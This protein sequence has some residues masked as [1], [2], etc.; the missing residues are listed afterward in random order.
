MSLDNTNCGSNANDNNNINSGINFSNN[1]FNNNHDLLLHEACATGDALKL[2][3]L[4][5]SIRR[6]K[7]EVNAADE[8]WGDR[9]ALHWAACKGNDMLWASIVN[10]SAKF[11]AWPQFSTLLL[12]SNRFSGK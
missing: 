6:G 12:L 2:E 1:N 8:D 7:I 4:G 5:N 10:Q 3:E 9:T 11:C